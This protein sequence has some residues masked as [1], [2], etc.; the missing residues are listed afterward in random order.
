MNRRL[1]FGSPGAVP[2]FAGV[3]F[4]LALVQ[5]F[6]L[7][8][9]SLGLRLGR[10][11]A[12]GGLLVIILLS[13][14]LA[15]RFRRHSLEAI[16]APAPE[17]RLRGVSWTAWGVA[18]GALAWA[19]F[20]WVRLWRLASLRPCYDWD[21]LYYHLPAIGGWAA[22]GRVCWLNG[23]ADV[24]FVN[25]PMGVEVT[26][27]FMHLVL[28]TS[29]LAT[30][31]NLWYWPLAFLAVVVIA[32]MLGVRGPWRWVSGAWIAG[33]SGLVCQSVTGYSDPGSTATAMGALAAS[34]LLVFDR[35]T[36]VV[37]RLVLWG[38][39]LGLLAGAKG[40]GAPFAAVLALSV[41][42]VVLFQGRNDWQR[43]L[44]RLGLAAVIA[45]AVGGYWYIRNAIVTGNPIYPVELKFGA[46]V[47]IPGYDRVNFVEA[48]LPAWLAAYPRFLRVPVSWLQLDAPIRG[49]DPVGGMGFLWLFGCLPAMFLLVF[50]LPPRRSDPHSRRFLFF[51]AL[52]V[53]LLASETSP[54]WSRFTIWLLALGLP[55]LAWVLQLGS[56]AAR[57]W[58]RPVALLLLAAASVLAIW[59]SNRTAGLEEQTG[60][61]VNATASG[62]VYASSAD[63]LFPR[64]LK[65]AGIDRFMA[66][67]K[68]A[69]SPWGRLGTLF[70][71]V[72]SQP[73][74][75]REIVLLPAT[76]VAKDFERLAAEGVTWV[77]W[78]VVGAGQPP[79]VL[80]EAAAEEIVYQSA[81]DVDFRF[82]RLRTGPA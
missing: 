68:I 67:G 1:S 13:A 70:G 49:Y 41:C 58:L 16:A 11:A 32:L 50:L 64:F 20:L 30:A 23:G 82:F 28:G 65:T 37:W 17:A 69:R 18:A 76:P 40:T 55:S 73:L 27:F 56:T 22:Q 14:W 61:I 15:S 33:T 45:L 31:G 3:T 53:L 51:G 35:G 5:C 57:R 8:S 75:A 81:S 59:E 43:W 4:F 34:G 52:A 60:K 19:A 25:Y 9:G 12:V 66:A 29:R 7:G 79:E 47:L 78:D 42:V 72:L 62:P 39:A 6:C 2:V 21:G 36:P 38:A 44:W 54:W 48:N 63:R 46:K 74:G 71:G 26:T 24:P 77:I 80:R 10:P